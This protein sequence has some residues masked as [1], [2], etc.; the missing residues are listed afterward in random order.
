MS[1]P[2]EVRV[3]MQVLEEATEVDALTGDDFTPETIWWD[4]S[5]AG[6]TVAAFSADNKS[7][8]TW[9]EW[10]EESS[11]EN[12][13]DWVPAPPGW[14]DQAIADTAKKEEE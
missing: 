9:T 11:V 1:K 8:R 14:F 13:P 2:N 5:E 4:V 12:L 7:I 3:T 6:L 10:N